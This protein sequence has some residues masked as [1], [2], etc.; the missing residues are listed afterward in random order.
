[1]VDPG[2]EVWLLTDGAWV[3][4]LR[5][6]HLNN[7]S[8]QWLAFEATIYPDK[9]EEFDIFRICKP[10]PCTFKGTAFHKGVKFHHITSISIRP[11]NDDDIPLP[12]AVAQAP[13]VPL[14]APYTSPVKLPSA[15]H[16]SIIFGS[17]FLYVSLAVILLGFGLKFKQ[18]LTEFDL[19]SL[20]EGQLEA[21]L[22]KFLDSDI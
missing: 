3:E 4:V 19:R 7:I 18:V 15:R 8:A 17:K 21:G 11:L 10:Q 20:L 5:T 6:R 22:T 16:R 13:P 12:P 2:F 14:P 9:L 1:M